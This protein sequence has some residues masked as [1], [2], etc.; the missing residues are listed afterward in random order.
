MRLHQPVGIWLLLWPCLWSV[1]LATHGAPIVLLLLFSI[2]A[3]LMRS[4]GCIVNDIAD[5]D[6]DRQVERTRTRPLASGELSLK[7]ALALLAFL[8]AASACIALALGWATILWAALSLIPVMLYPWMKRI[9]WWPQ[10]FLGLTF[11][12]G[13]LLGWVAVNGTVQ[14]PALA[15]Y[16]GGFF[17][18]L[19]YDTIYAHQDKRDDALIGVKST[20]LK[21]G[22]HSKSAITAFYVCAILCWAAAGWL[23]HTGNLYFS[24]LMLCQLHLLHQACTVDL[25]SPASCRATF[26][27]NT[28][29]GLL[30]FIG[31]L[32]AFK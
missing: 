20:A 8:L 28:W 22:S 11:N 29:L 7:Q 18:T 5:R 32:A 26:V 2:G 13:A 12:W 10:A 16:I 1:A 24:V 9:T 31:T 15:L 17:W 19:G 14:P 27:S 23:A 25:D 21:L 6:I 3:V 4:A 30:L